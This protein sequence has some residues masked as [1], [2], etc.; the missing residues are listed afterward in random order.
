MVSILFTSLESGLLYAPFILGVFLTFRILNFPDLTVDSSF[1]TGAAS[2]AMALKLGIPG[3]PAL[4]VGFFAGFL[5][6]CLTAFLHTRLGISKILSG[7]LSLSMLY[8]VNLHIMGG[9][10]ISLLNEVKVISFFHAPM[11]NAIVIIF[12]LL[13]ITLVK[14]LIDWFLLSEFGLQLRATGDNEFTAKSLAVNTNTMKF[15]GISLSNGLVGLSG[16]LVSQFQGFADIS[17]GTGTV[18]IALAA[19]M[20]GE[21]IIFNNKISTA[22][23]GI[24]VGSILYQ[25]IINI[26]LRFGLAGSD[27]K[28]IA[29]VIV[30][31]ALLISNNKNIVSTYGKKLFNNQ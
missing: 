23:Y 10:N 27:L 30:I 1:V 5:G 8:T 13:V 7:I 17:M 3:I 2:T 26:A 20:L 9:P 15:I 21:T 16:G 22:T 4:I 24:I 11:N 25:L 28:F 14:L 19:L 18:V 6:G 29:A 31:F 12:L